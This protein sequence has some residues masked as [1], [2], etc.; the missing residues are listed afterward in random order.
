MEIIDKCNGL[1]IYNSIFKALVY[2][3][4]I[5]NLCILVFS[6]EFFLFGVA[7]EYIVFYKGFLCIFVTIIIFAICFVNKWKVVPEWFKYK[8]EIIEL[9]R[10]MYFNRGKFL[11]HMR[12]E[13]MLM[14]KKKDK[15]KKLYCDNFG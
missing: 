8:D 9:Y 7:G 13:E 2:I 15:E 14:K 11:P 10:K 1:K 12:I 6:R 5:S 3:G 4:V